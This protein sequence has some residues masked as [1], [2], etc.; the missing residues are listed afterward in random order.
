MRRECGCMPEIDDVKAHTASSSSPMRPFRAMKI[1]IL[2][3]SSKT[4]HSTRADQTHCFK[5]ATPAT[6]RLL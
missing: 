1:V 6:R 2:L 3:Y 4:V 5:S